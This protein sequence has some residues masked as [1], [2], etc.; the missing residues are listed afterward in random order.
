M[1]MGDKGVLKI[2]WKDNEP[3]GEGEF[4]SNGSSIKIRYMNGAR[5]YSQAS[6]IEE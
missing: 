4:M 6:Q 1:Q 2:E 5:R 3:H